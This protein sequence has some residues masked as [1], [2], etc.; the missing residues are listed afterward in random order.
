MFEIRIARTAFDETGR[1]VSEMLS[2]MFFHA[3]RRYE[4]IEATDG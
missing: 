2:E 3:G 1:G 4:E